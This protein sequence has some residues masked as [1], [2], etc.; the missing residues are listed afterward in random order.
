MTKKSNDEKF[1]INFFQKGNNNKQIVNV[2]NV[3][4]NFN[5]SDY[6]PEEDN[7]NEV[8]EELTEIE[9]ELDKD[10]KR[11]ISEKIGKKLTEKGYSSKKV[12]PF[13]FYIKTREE[14]TAALRQTLAFA[15]DMAESAVRNRDDGDF[16]QF[17]SMTVLYLSDL[18]EKVEAEDKKDGENNA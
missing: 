8:P 16:L 11:L 10:K 6:M 17:L 18:L 12:G 15:K 9:K 4:Q 13:T 3:T 7:D 14:Y 5:E 1:V 2:Q